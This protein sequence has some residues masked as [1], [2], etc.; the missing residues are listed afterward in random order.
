MLEPVSPVVSADRLRRR[1]VAGENVG[2]HLRTDDI[3]SRAGTTSYVTRFLR[4]EWHRSPARHGVHP[5]DVFHAVDGALVIADM[6]DADS[7]FRTLVLG[8]DCAGNLLEVIVLPVA[9]SPLR[10]GW[11]RR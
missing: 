7:P 4:V 10:E 6:G 11:P 8:P 3:G 9:S 1:R 5:D 2:E